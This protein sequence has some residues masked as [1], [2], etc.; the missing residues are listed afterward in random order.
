MLEGMKPTGGWSNPSEEVLTSPLSTCLDEEDEDWQQANLGALFA[1]S[2]TKYLLAALC[3]AVL[4]SAAAITHLNHMR[5]GV[6]VG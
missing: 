6:I 4:A 5:L 1:S 3:Q 2:W